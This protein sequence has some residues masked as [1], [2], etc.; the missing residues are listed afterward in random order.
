MHA[1][2]WILR[3]FFFTIITTAHTYSQWKK[4][5]FIPYCDVPPETFY[6]KR[7]NAGGGLLF[8]FVDEIGEVRHTSPKEVISYQQNIDFGLVSNYPYP[9]HSNTP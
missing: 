4:R 6:Q 8:V 5:L 9:K 1:T 3:F 7:K 2:H